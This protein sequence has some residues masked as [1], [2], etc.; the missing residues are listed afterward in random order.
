[1]Y[2]VLD[3]TLVLVPFITNAERHAAIVQD[4]VRFQA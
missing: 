3:R 2:S 4:V 1:M